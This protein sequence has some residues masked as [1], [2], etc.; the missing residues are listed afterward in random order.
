MFFD[1]RLCL[2]CINNG[3]IFMN[4]RS[5]RV[6]E[7]PKI[8]NMLEKKCTSFLG[9]EKAKKLRPISCPDIIKQLQQET[10]EEIGRA[11]V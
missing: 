11:H 4:E 5:L 10:G 2:Y 9:K 7:Y 1:F 6:L 3:V 8:V